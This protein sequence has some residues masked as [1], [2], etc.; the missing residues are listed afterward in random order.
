MLL[1]RRALTHSDPALSRMLCQ[2]S[3]SVPDARALA[4]EMNGLMSSNSSPR[5]KAVS[6]QSQAIKRISPVCPSIVL[7]AHIAWSSPLIR[8]MVLNGSLLLSGFVF[9]SPLMRVY[10]PPR[11]GPCLRIRFNVV[12]VFMAYCTVHYSLAAFSTITA[13]TSSALTVSMRIP[14][15]Q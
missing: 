14:R 5:L 15:L 8:R 13:N 2:S 10:H 6:M 9:L 4:A 1:S 11:H 7:V 12:Y 3:G